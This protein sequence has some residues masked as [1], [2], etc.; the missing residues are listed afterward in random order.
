MEHPRLSWG[1]RCVDDFD[2]IA[3]IGEGTYGQVYKAKVVNDGR[4]EFVALKKVT[5][6][7]QTVKHCDV[8][9]VFVDSSTGYILKDW[10]FLWGWALW[11][12]FARRRK[13]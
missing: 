7:N 1:E 10:L 9:S 3:Q 8:S 2:I 13:R 4:E 11:L 5:G 6:R 12:G